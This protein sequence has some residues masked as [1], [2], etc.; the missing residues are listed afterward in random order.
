M[1]YL[2][3]KEPSFTSKLCKWKSLKDL[4]FPV[5]SQQK[6]KGCLIGLV[7]LKKKVSDKNSVYM[8][9]CKIN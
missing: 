9:A 4:I 8:K 7:I 5:C 6:K 1:I 2:E 3:H